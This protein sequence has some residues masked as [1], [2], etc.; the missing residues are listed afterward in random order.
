[1]AIDIKLWRMYHHKNIDY[2]DLVDWLYFLIEDGYL[3]YHLG[4][5]ATKNIV[6]YILF[7]WQMGLNR[8]LAFTMTLYSVSKATV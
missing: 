8:Q 2:S 5:F 1:M 4:P 7:S 3:L 6:T